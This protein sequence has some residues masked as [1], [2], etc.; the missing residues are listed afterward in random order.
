MIVGRIN[1][2][3]KLTDAGVRIVEAGFASVLENCAA[4]NIKSAASSE[5]LAESDGRAEV[6]T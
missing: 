4:I 5:L 6:E 3:F 2:P 1:G